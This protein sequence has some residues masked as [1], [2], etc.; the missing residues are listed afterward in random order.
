[1]Q[2]LAGLTLILTATPGLDFKKNTVKFSFRIDLWS[3][4]IKKVGKDFCNRLAS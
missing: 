3:A 4:E 1:L 2:R